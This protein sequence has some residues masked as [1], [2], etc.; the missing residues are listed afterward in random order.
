ME[1]R[2]PYLVHT[3]FKAPTNFDVSLADIQEE[4]PKRTTAESQ[5]PAQY[6]S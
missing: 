5:A 2:E 4:Q 1:V 3:V 6:I